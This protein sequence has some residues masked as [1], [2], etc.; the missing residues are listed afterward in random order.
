MDITEEELPEDVLEA[1]NMASL[2][3]LP[4]KSREKYEKQYE[5]FSKWCEQR[6]I[7]TL[8][9]EVLLAYFLKLSKEFKP[10]TM[11]SKYSML[12]NVIKIK[13][14]IDIG[15][16]Y[17][18][19]AFLKKQN[20]GFKPKKAKIFTKE[21]IFSFINSAPDEIYLLIKVAT[22]FGLAGACRREELA[23]LTT[24]DIEDKENLIIVKIRNSK[25]HTARNF[26]ISEEIHNGAYLQLYRK[27][28]SLRPITSNN[29]FFLV[30][31]KD[32]CVSQ[33]VGVNSFGKMPSE[34]AAFLKLPNPELY[35]GHSFRRSSATLLA[36]SG[37]G[38]TDI[39]R[40]GGWKST[41]VA[42]GYIDE[43]TTYKKGLSNKILSCSPKKCEAVPSTSKNGSI[44]SFCN[45]TVLMNQEMTSTTTFS[46]LV[47]R[48]AINVEKATN[49]TFHINVINNNK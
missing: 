2:Q 27:Y 16:F 46:P 43:S 33:C 9:E 49:C 45:T 10:N 25:N 19:T 41:A 32:K 36:N 28:K 35:T 18:L 7:K 47:A 20:I 44:Y 21:E 4:A 30:Y 17:K 37:E 6:G 14:D 38:I 12:K 31:K 22:I 40:L 3:L 5:L 24:A 29:R 48:S 34:I 15:E 23:N 13:R 8:K 26:I 39:K 42:E 11:W 1:A